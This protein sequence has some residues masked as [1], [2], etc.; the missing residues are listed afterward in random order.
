MDALHEWQ[1]PALPSLDRD[2][3]RE[4]KARVRTH[5]DRL[6]AGRDRWYRRNRSYHD[7]LERALRRLVPPGRSVLELGCGTGNL[8]KALQPARGVGIDLSPAMVDLS[9]QK[10]PE[11]RFEVD[12]A[13]AVEGDEPFD[14]IVA[15]DLIGELLDIAAMLDRLH[16]ISA[17]ETR[18]I[19]TF[20]NPA[21]EGLLRVAQRAGLTMP[22]ARQNWIG[23]NDVT[24]L[25]E[26]SDFTVEQVHSGLLLPALLPA[27]NRI[28]DAV[29]A[30][31]PLIGYLNAV[32]IVVARPRR[33]RPQLWPLSCS[34]IVPCR[35][36]VGNIEAAV[37]RMPSM[38]SH[39]EIV[40][41]DG[42]S[43]DGTGERIEEMRRRFAGRKDIRL[44]HQVP[45]PR[46]VVLASV[47]P[48]APVAMLKLGKG[49]AVRKGFEAA[50]G[51]VL[52]ILDADLTVPPEDLPRFFN[53]IASGKAEFVNGSR[54]LYPMEERAMKFINYLGNKL[55][56]SLFTW[57]LGQA[58]RDTLCG[59]KAVRR[60]AYRRIADGRAYFGEFDPF[61]DFD[62]LFGAARLGLRIVDV[63]VRYRRRRN[64]VTKV[65]VVR[66][67]LLLMAMSL[68]AF[69]KFKLSKWIHTWR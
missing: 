16:V 59:T 36:E 27:L 52:M 13:E 35:N 42:A 43:S 20:H 45:G 25:L 7:Y 33:P 47:A 48:D 30:R 69:R 63:P 31:A 61:G 24:G 39:T 56:S 28:A 68:V 44:I 29:P 41:V 40:F 26:L 49:D 19:L 8:L 51:D 53:A 5:Y 55:F 67:G 66:H 1:Q 37:S 46:P 17:A 50:R 10:Y 22:P 4:F 60:E 12:D 15:S 38:G 54:L 62:L 21:L 18:L 2:P 34:V 64:G 6:A 23:P 32:T 57:I 14:V 58:V 3:D 11:M 65:R 9:R